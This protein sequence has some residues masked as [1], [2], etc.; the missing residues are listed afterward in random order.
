MKQRE[1]TM[2][3]AGIK[4]VFSN[5]ILFY[6]IDL[7]VS[8]LVYC[9]MFINVVFFIENLKILELEVNSVAEKKGFSI[10]MNLLINN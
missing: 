5:N 10:L 7:T 3:R 1:R 2:C 6:H 8:A 9:S 4:V